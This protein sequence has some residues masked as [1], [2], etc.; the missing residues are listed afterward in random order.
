MGI[1]LGAMALA[2]VL[3]ACGVPPQAPMSA[4][5]PG[6]GPGYPASAPAPSTRQPYFN[7]EVA[8][9]APGR[10]NTA[11]PNGFVPVAEAPVSTF[12]ADVDTA[13]YAV[14]RRLLNEGHPIPFPV[15]RVEEMVNY[16]HYD[17][18]R[19]ESPAAP[20]RPTVAVY[21]SPWTEGA[22][23]LHI[24]IRAY[25]VARRQRP[26]LNLVFLV[27]VSGSMAPQDRL[28]LLKQAL[29]MLVDDLRPDDHVAIVSYAANSGV[30]LEPTAGTDK[31]TIRAA[32][33]G[34]TTGGLTAGDGGIQA[35][36]ALAERNFDKTAVNRVVIGTDGDFNVGIVD[37][38]E[39][40]AL[41]AEKRKTGVYLSV[42][43]VGL[44]NLN[45]VVMQRLAQAGNGNAAYIDGMQEAKKVLR[46]EL[47]STMVPVADNVKF[48][49]EFNPALVGQYRLI[50]YETRALRR[51]DFNND[52]VDAGD[53]GA[54]HAVTALYEFLPPGARGKGVD[55]LRYEASHKV[56]TTRDAAN[57]DE[58]GFL[59]LRY[60]LPGQS[61]SRLIERPIRKG[62]ALASVE[63]A[64]AEARFALAVASFAGKLRSEGGGET[65]SYAQIA[66]LAR[67]ARGADPHG[68][69]AE[70]IRLV[71]LAGSRAAR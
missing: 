24:G 51:E 11:S 15:L 17:Y 45:D 41:I 70:F 50:G 21:P 56:K 37:P 5:P 49:I 4:M 68:T 23:I 25:D 42:L 66:D 58:F 63:A 35:A 71:E 46:D 34:L 48:Q 14:V 2:T 60:T 33:Q 64:P 26:A 39:L 40:E 20:F 18:P 61:K 28:P 53:V 57:A 69:R 52:R 3:T 1:L 44:G 29:L 9:A 30:V 12:S 62:A 8:A 65:M 19:P 7:A 32:I 67:G 38:K 47:S 10:F 31:E 6:G 54:G 55:P 16:F 13:S 36:Y 43:G 22:R 59:R 27:D